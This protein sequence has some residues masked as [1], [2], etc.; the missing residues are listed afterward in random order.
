MDGA[1]VMVEAGSYVKEEVVR[2]V[3]VLVTNTPQ[4]HTYAVRSFYRAL[5]ENLATASASFV[6]CAAWF[7]GAPFATHVTADLSTIPG[8]AHPPG[9][10]LYFGGFL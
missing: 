3:V 1:Q 6:I 10:G 2:G 7:I 4:L 5:K 8:P 9:G